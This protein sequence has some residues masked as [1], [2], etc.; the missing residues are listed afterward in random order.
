MTPENV[1]VRRKGESHVGQIME[2]L[3]EKLGA[4]VVLCAVYIAGN[5]KVSIIT[6]PGMNGV[7]AERCAKAVSEAL[8][9]II[10]VDLGHGEN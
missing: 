6:Y 4:K 7:A 1:T 5:G 2:A 10:V 8:G 3:R 9:D